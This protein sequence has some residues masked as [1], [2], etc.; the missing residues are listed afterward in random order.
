MH[1]RSNARTFAVVVVVLCLP[2]LAFPASADDSYKP[3]APLKLTKC[4]VE[5]GAEAVE[6]QAPVID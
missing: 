5:V 6:C 2:L 1:F 3:L 4:Q